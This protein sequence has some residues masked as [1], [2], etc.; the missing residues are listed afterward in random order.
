MFTRSPS[1]PEIFCIIHNAL[2]FE[3]EETRIKKR[4]DRSH[5]LAEKHLII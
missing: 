5:F 4:P 1:L 2:V 3:K